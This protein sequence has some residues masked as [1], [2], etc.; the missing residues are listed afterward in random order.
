MRP[1]KVL[2]LDPTPGSAAAVDRV[3]GVLRSVV[4]ALAQSRQR[5]LSAAGPAS[6]WQG[7][8][9]SVV[10]EALEPLSRRLRVLEDDV[11]DFSQAWQRWRDGLAERQ[12]ETAELTD[13]MA[14][15][16]SQEVAPAAARRGVLVAQVRRLADEHAQAAANLETAADTLAE[17]LAASAVEEGDSVTS[18]AS[19]LAALTASTATLTVATLE[20]LGRGRGLARRPVRAEDP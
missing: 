2:R 9:G 10:G 4:L 16:E 17:A 11:V 7:P 13:A 6:V 3:S 15:T 20:A 14:A 5:L 12:A 19:A 1:E 18:F 8:G